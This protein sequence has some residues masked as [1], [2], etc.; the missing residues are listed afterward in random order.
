MVRFINNFSTLLYYCVK[1]SFYERKP[2]V[3]VYS[4]F[5]HA[6]NAGTFSHYYIYIHGFHG[7]RPLY[8]SMQH[9]LKVDAYKNE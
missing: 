7:K 8:I 4:I 5:I 2:S 6:V 9:A 3:G 1:V